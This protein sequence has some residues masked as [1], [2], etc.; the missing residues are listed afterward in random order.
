MIL[1][2]ELGSAVEAGGKLDVVGTPLAKARAFALGKLPHLDAL[3]PD[4]DKSYL[5]LQKLLRAAPDIKRVAMPVIG[6]TQVDQ[7]RVAMEE[8]GT[9]AKWE[10]IPAGQLR[11]TQSEIWFDKVIGFYVEHGTPKAGSRATE[12]PLI[13]S[14]RGD[15]IDGHHRWAQVFFANPS[16]TMNALRVDLALQPLLRVS[17]EFSV[18]VLGRQPKA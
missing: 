5:A 12:S 10:R 4:F 18:S 8:A 13:T 2:E 9:S 1:S 14:K 7:F 16:M 15:L 3:L 11:P 6:P 17:R